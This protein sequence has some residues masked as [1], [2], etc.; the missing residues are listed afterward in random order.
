MIKA[1]L[2]DVIG[3]TILEKD[4]T[5]VV[6]CVDD[7]FQDYGIVVDRNLIQANRGREK[8]AMISTLVNELHLDPELVPKIYDSFC[9]HLEKNLYNFVPQQDAMETFEWLK[10]LRLHIGIGTGLS[11]DLLE[12]ILR[13]V[14]WRKEYFDFVGYPTDKIRGRPYPDMI[15][16]MMKTLGL[17]APQ[18]ILKIGD[19]VSDI[20]EGKNAGTKTA[21]LL[22]T[23]Q[24]HH[25]L[26]D[27]QPDFVCTSLSEL[28]KII[29][30]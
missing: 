16:A 3:T 30:P 28:R 21:V 9:I 19:T 20:E 7:A 23:S 18:E 27:A 17:S 5:T 22:S 2:F 24:P 29:Q 26:M 4:P 15:H 1:V 25:V 13:H 8:V 6:R 11:P 14:Q 10:S 12:M